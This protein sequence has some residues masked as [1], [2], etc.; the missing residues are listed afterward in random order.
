MEIATSLRAA[1]FRNKQTYNTPSVC[2]FL[3]IVNL[4]CC[5]SFSKVIQIY[6]DIYIY[7]FSYP[8]PVCILNVEKSDL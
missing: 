4:Q 2:V 3:S 5:V 8:F 1:Q 7:S 6:I